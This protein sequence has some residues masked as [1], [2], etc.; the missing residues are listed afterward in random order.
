VSGTD[1]LQSQKFPIPIQTNV[2]PLGNQR[3]LLAAFN[4]YLGIRT[5][6]IGG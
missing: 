6:Q 5:A 1:R 3:A 2:W 4:G